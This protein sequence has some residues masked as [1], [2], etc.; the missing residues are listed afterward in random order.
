MKSTALS[1]CQ[2]RPRS[3]LDGYRSF[4]AAVETIIGLFKTEVINR[5]GPW[6][7]KERVEWETLQWVDW[8]NTEL[9]LEPLGNITPIEGGE[10]RKSIEV[11]QNHSLKYELNSLR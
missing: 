1:A 6:K 3:R 5:M 10:I 11:R 9:L 7:S 4:N 2:N 8:F